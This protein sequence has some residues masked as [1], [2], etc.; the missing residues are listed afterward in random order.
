[1]RPEGH[2]L[3]VLHVIAPSRSGGL[4]TVVVQLTR[5]LR[6]RGND[7]HVAVVLEPGTERDH[8]VVRALEEGGV[9][10]HLLVIG[11]RRY[12]SERRAI[13]S[14]LREL[15]A[16]VLHTHGFRADT[17]LSGIAQSE[18]RAHI[19]TF[20]GFVGGSIRS[21]FY[22]WLQVQ[23]ARFASGAIAVSNSIADS[24]CA[25]GVRKNVRVLRNAI[26]RPSGILSRSDSRRA[27]NLPVDVP[28]IGWVGRFSHEKDPYLFVDALS[29]SRH[30]IHGAMIGEG[31]L[32]RGA[33]ARAQSLGIEQRLH[34]TGMLTNASRYL[35]AFDALALT[36]ST[37]GTPIILLECMWLKVPIITTAV[38][39]VPDLVTISE[40]LLCPNR[41]AETISMA[42]EQLLTGASETTI[43]SEAALR[44]AGEHFSTDNWLSEHEQ[45]YRSVTPK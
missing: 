6:T 9:P 42:I 14:L 39:G 30:D 40:A 34:F 23:S 25:H 20:H 27:L 10:V 17:V 13:R 44:R 28:V 21:K 19:L 7:I 2:G 31:P 11:K 22:E 36:S 45:L 1:M 15:N 16:T 41:N 43:R 8:P 4:E 35:Q 33:Q 24:L 18:G 37:E 38:G 3:R 5:G 29:K 32:L 26:S 12:L